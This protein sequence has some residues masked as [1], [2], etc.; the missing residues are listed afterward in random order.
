VPARAKMGQDA[1][2]GNAAWY[3]IKVCGFELGYPIRRFCCHCM[4]KYC[5]N[6][7]GVEWARLQISGRWLGKIQSQLIRGER[8]IQPRS[9]EKLASCGQLGLAW[10]LCVIVGYCLGNNQ[11]AR[12][13]AG[14]YEIVDG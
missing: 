6:V 3:Y 7:S 4:I 5:N 9:I 12:T 10:S 1:K 11:G 13:S 2:G 8:N 14:C